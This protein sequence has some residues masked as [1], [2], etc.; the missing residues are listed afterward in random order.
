MGRGVKFLPGSDRRAVYSVA[1]VMDRL[2]VSRHTVKLFVKQ[3]QLT[4]KRIG[5]RD[6][7]TAGSVDRA[8]ARRYADAE[9]AAAPG[10][11]GL[12]SWPAD[13]PR[14]A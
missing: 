7:L 9:T 12:L 1:E 11:G 4:M 10:A 8:L 2:G 14:A 3:G 6:Y 5:L 13:S